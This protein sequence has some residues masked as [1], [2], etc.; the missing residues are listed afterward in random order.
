MLILW[1][2]QLIKKK[3]GRHKL[4]KSEMKEEITVGPWTWRNIM[5]NSLITH[6]V[7]DEMDL[8]FGDTNDSNSH[9]GNT[10]YV[11]IFQ[12]K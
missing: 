4:L 2:D 9:R 3:K 1:K 6:L 5:K 7:T 8:S 10:E 11:Y 12:R